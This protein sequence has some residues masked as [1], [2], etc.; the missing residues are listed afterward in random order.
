M[1]KANNFHK[2]SWK[3]HSTNAE[4]RLSEKYFNTGYISTFNLECNNLN[5][6]FGIYI[7]TK[8]SDG[9]S[10]RQLFL[11]GKN[12][13]AVLSEGEQKVIAL[14]DFI[15][16]TNLSVINNGIIFDDPVTSLDEERKSII[17]ERLVTIAKD[18]QV[19][20]FTH[21][22]VFVSSLINHSV[23]LDV[24]QECHWVE[25]TGNE[26]GIIWLRNTPS[27]EKSYKKS[28]K[29]QSFYDKA[30]I[31]QPEE[32]EINIK[33]GFAALRTSYEALVIFDL[34]EG[35][36]QRFNERVSV[37]SLSSVYF[38]EQI[39]DEIIDSFSQCCRYMEGHS[40][41][42]KY[43]YKK[44]ESD[45]LKEEIDRFIAVKKKIKKL[46]KAHNNG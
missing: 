42:D 17:A 1:R 25:S 23:E 30:K 32:R 5:G 46:K 4:K 6:N 40:H 36:V 38:D 20:I 24:Q 15:A 13:S 2:S 33:N 10:N 34:F 11:K 21:D 14:A 19:I 26:I 43:G 12:P 29:A 28:G 8:S 37:D 3:S 16:E 22:L 31:A 45:N 18:K 9:H 7:D 39:R 41:S 44:P 35:V 27:Y